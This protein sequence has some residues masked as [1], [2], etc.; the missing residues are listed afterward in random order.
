MVVA[1]RIDAAYGYARIVSKISIP[2]CSMRMVSSTLTLKQTRHGCVSQT[3]CGWVYQPRNPVGDAYTRHGHA[4]IDLW[5]EEVVQTKRASDF[6]YVA[7]KW[8]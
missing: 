6:G 7:S 8:R 3:R 1:S 4:D 5:R 2:V